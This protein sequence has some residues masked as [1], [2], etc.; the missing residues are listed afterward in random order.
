MK[1]LIQKELRENLKTASLGLLVFSILAMGSYRYY[2]GMIEDAAAGLR[3]AGGYSYRLQPLT[4]ALTL[5]QTAM[6]CAL[7]GTF[8]GWLQIQRERHRDLWA[9]LVHRPVDRTTIYL[10]K[11][12]AGLSLYL[13]AA[14]LP[15]GCYILWAA[16]PGNVA[17]PFQV[18][19]IWPFFTAFLAG[20]AFYFAGMLSSLRQAR[21]YFSRTF[22]V[23][24]AL[25]VWLTGMQA[26]WSFWPILAT[27]LVG[28]IILAIAAWGSFVSHG[29]YTGQPALGR[30]ALI[31]ALA[32]GA[33][34][35]VFLVTTNLVNALPSWLGG[36]RLSNYLLTRDGAVYK[37]S[38]GGGQTGEI[39]DLDG[40]PFVDPKSGQRIQPAE[41]SPYFCA[42]VTS[43]NVDPEGRR[44]KDDYPRT[45]FNFWGQGQGTLW[46]YSAPRRR[47]VGY[48]LATRRFVGSLG[49]KGFAT[50]LAGDGDRFDAPIRYYNFPGTPLTLRTATAIYRIDVQDRTVKTIFVVDSDDLI[51][52]QTDIEAYGR[53]WDK[54]TLVVT[55][56][57]VCL[58]KPDGAEVWKVPYQPAY[59][60]YPDIGVSFLQGSGQFVLWLYPSTVANRNAGWK[61]PTHLVWI[62]PGSGVLKTAD[63]TSLPGHREINPAEKVV[64]LLSPAPVWPIFLWQENRD[65][66]W[67]LPW[68]LMCLS[69]AGA[70]IFWVP[71]GWWF[72]RR[73]NFTIHEQLGWAVFHLVF[74]LPGFLTFLGV[75]EWPAR[76]ACPKCHKLRVVDRD[77]C[78]HCGAEFVP[79]EKDGTEIF[80]PL[81]ERVDLAVN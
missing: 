38:R 20:V 33:M 77:Q 8:L 42:N 65:W 10:S 67:T 11:V 80:E 71:A 26:T 25:L 59:P 24:M 37:E 14:G 63:L 46:Y 58:L 56:R 28:I 21:W 75:Q 41:L 12:I 55:K 15:L 61:L 51:L 31:G 34:I 2:A 30:L 6:L 23:G 9:F 57:L 40:K 22:G 60:D 19:M 64:A 29:Q 13:V 74:N 79:P 16:A 43:V 44:P 76:V 52:S 53:D 68:N 5:V 3:N 1:T 47:L 81:N 45:Y 72:G 49:P 36:V 73:Y 32:P 27:M 69:L 48:N 39:V 50:D 54:N 17:A 62:K 66:S 4:T 35:L 70:A 78:E 7:F 18:E